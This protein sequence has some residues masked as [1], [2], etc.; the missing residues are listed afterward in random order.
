M[1]TD[2][3]IPYIDASS[4]RALAEM[5]AELGPLLN[6]SGR[7]IQMERER[8]L[9]WTFAGGRINHTFKYG[10]QLLSDWKDT[11]GNFR[12]K[13]EGDGLMFERLERV[14]DVM[15]DPAFWKDPATRDAITRSLPEYRLSKFQRALPRAFSAEMVCD[16]LLDIEGAWRCLKEGDPKIKTDI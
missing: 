8:A 1:K 3:E 15:A 16:F 6:R 11:A 13:I 12:V 5:R 4:S 14:I 10:I 2:V 9:W 7:A